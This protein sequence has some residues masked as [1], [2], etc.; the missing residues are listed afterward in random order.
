MSNREN[1]KNAMTLNYLKGNKNVYRISSPNKKHHVLVNKNSLF[2]LVKS[3]QIPTKKILDELIAKTFAGRKNMANMVYHSLGYNYPFYSNWGHR[4]SVTPM[5]KYVFKTHQGNY[6]IQN[7][8]NPVG[9]TAKLMLKNVNK[10]TLS[11]ANIRALRSLRRQNVK[12]TANFKRKFNAQQ[13]KRRAYLVRAKNIN[14]QNENY[15]VNNNG[16][17]IHVNPSNWVQT[18]N[19]NKELVNTMREHFNGGN[20]K[21]F[22]LK[23]KRG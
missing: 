3:Q 6:G 11:N 14:G 23:M 20:V 19:Y 15:W 2:Q 16:Q 22:K 10:N 7:V 17:N 9:Y 12:N 21:V 18:N 8:R 5:N 1:L 13:A 4:G